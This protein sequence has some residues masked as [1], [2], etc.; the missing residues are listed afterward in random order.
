[1]ELL[2][3]AKL[4]PVL[5]T[6]LSQDGPDSGTHLRTGEREERVLTRD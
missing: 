4:Q 5:T 2:S 3:L 6:S 1:M